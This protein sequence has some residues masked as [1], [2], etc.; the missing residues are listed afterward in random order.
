MLC[1][2]FPSVIEHY[3][4]ATHTPTFIDGMLY[5]VKVSNDDICVNGVMK[6]NKMLD[7]SIH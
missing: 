6:I 5:K 7:D 4:P 2:S 3:I 1:K